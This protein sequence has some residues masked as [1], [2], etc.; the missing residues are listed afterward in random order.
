MGLA[1]SYPSG[2]FRVGNL[3]KREVF[4]RKA[5]SWHPVAAEPSE[6][7]QGK[8]WNV[9]GSSKSVGA[10]KEEQIRLGIVNVQVKLQ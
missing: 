10:G 9:R 6:E 8:D 5:G 2:V 7:N 3:V 4:H 1:H